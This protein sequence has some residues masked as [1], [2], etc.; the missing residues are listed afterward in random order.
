[1]HSDSLC[2]KSWQLVSTAVFKFLVFWLYTTHEN[3]VR[4]NFSK[5]FSVAN[6]SYR[7]PNTSSQTNIR[8]SYQEISLWAT[9]FQGH[10]Y[11]SPPQDIILCQMKA[12]RIPKSSIF[13]IHL[14]LS[15][16]LRQGLQTVITLL[17][18]SSCNTK[19][20]TFTEVFCSENMEDRTLSLVWPEMYLLL[21][22]TLSY[23]LVWR[24]E[25][26]TTCLICFE[27][28]CTL[29]LCLWTLHYPRCKQGV[30]P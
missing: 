21:E 27:N 6:N 8:S 30:F 18:I 24:P 26:V 29:M 4:N 19:L 1:M 17:W 20:D 2:T 9:M 12:D 14:I 7:E 5:D 10:H 28:H 15:S 11:K 22:T 16:Q 23:L 25:V 3:I 13:Q